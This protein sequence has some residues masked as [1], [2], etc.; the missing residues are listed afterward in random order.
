MLILS[1]CCLSDSDPSKTCEN[2]SYTGSPFM[3]FNLTQ[4][5]RKE[6]GK[7]Q[8]GELKEVTRQYNNIKYH[9][10]VK[11][12]TY[13]CCCLTI[14]TNFLLYFSILLF[15]VLMLAQ[16]EYLSLHQI[17]LDTWKLRHQRAGSETGNFV[18]NEI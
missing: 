1:K 17:T 14:N 8:M 2:P 4:E 9:S 16:Y 10:L 3:L 18:F 11:D 12:D 7:N 15:A 5:K 13:L 6:K